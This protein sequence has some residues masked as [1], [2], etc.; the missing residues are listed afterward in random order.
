MWS[1]HKPTAK[2]LIVNQWCREGVGVG[3][4]GGGYFIYLIRFTTPL[5]HPLPYFPPG[6][7]PFLLQASIV[8]DEG[9]APV[10]LQLLQGALCGIK[11]TTPTLPTSPV[12]AKRDKDKDKDKDGE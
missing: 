2:Q 5:A 4:G 9:V 7:L 11:T 1:T 6:V 12:K 3:G 10:L 8:L